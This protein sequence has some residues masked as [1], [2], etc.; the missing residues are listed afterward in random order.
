MLAVQS[1]NQIESRLHILSLEIKQFQNENFE[2]QTHDESSLN[3]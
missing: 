3:L 1:P 2:T